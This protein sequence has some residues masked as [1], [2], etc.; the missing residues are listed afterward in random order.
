MPD[1]RR[2]LVI[3]RSPDCDIVFDDDTV[4]R[5][6]AELRLEADGWTLVDLESSNGTFLT[7]DGLEDRLGRAQVTRFDALRFGAVPTTLPELFRRVGILPSA[8]GGGAA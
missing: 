8:G 4:S 5:H 7:R 3:G 6:H 1:A 2:V